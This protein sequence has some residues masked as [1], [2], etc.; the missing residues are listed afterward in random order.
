MKIVIEKAQHSW[1][2]SMEGAPRPYQGFLVWGNSQDEV[3][4]KISDAIKD[5]RK[6]SLL[7]TAAS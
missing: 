6:A 5:L 4:D 7:N 1:Y 2:A 3:L